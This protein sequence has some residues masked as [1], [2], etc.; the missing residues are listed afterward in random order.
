MSLR[1]V[2][3]YHMSETGLNGGL[4]DDGL[5]YRCCQVYNLESQLR[6]LLT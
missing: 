6:E 2:V 1:T 4:F 3:E 5:T